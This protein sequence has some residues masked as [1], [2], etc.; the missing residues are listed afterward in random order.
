MDERLSL[1]VFLS[2][3]GYDPQ[4]SQ[5]F[6]CLT[7]FSNFLIFS[8]TTLPNLR[9]WF[10]WVEKVVKSSTYKQLCPIFFTL[11]VMTPGKVKLLNILTIF[12]KLFE[13]YPPESEILV[14]MGRKGCGKLPCIRFLCSFFSVMLF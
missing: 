14:S 2:S 10:Q 6:D 1:I 4:K 11:K 9:I 8:K 5:V 3:K 7:V 12:V 13:T